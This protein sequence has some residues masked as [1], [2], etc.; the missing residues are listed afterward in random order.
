MFKTILYSFFILL[1]SN[2]AFAQQDSSETSSHAITI[3]YD[4]SSIN[5]P[6]LSDWNDRFME[7]RY[8]RN[9]T[10]QYYIRADHNHHFDLH[11]SGIELGTYFK[12]SSQVGIDLAAGGSDKS[13]FMPENFVRLGA[14][15]L[16][17]DNPESLGALVLYPSYQQSAYVNGD[18]KRFS[19]GSEYYPP[20][21]NA[22]FTPNLGF[23]R[24]QFGEETFSYGFGAHW[25]LTD[26]NRIGASY[27]FAPETENLITTTYTIR[28]ELHRDA[29]LFAIKPGK[30][31]YP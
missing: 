8:L 25:Q 20:S 11:D 5:R 7:Y 13:Y 1:L 3:G 17:F 6:E 18:V 2:T 12:L 24:D 4:K 15:F 16:L 27:S 28:R 19:L 23:V 26:F 9:D 30:F 14:S 21:I 22:W 10:I 29:E 31:L